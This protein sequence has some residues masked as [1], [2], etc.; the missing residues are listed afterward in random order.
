MKKFTLTL[1]AAG[2][3]VVGSA[4][5]ITTAS[6]TRTTAHAASARGPRGY[7]GYRGYRGNRGYR[8]PGGPAGP[9]GPQ[10]PV[11]PKGA[12]GGA[13]APGT[14]GAA[15]ATGREG[16]AGATGPAGPTGA[17]GP[18]GPGATS[19]TKLVGN[20]SSES[21]TINGIQLTETQ[22]FLGGACSAVQILN[23][24]SQPLDVFIDGKLAAPFIGLTNQNGVQTLAAPESTATFSAAFENGNAGV[25]GTVGDHYVTSGSG[26]CLTFGQF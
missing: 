21:V 9:A 20:G 17:T 19:F 13:G 3:L 2:L 14:A 24:T 10:G 22:P 6:A 11:G 1:A 5:G 15:G 7:R 4:Y 25:T 16:P 12:T 26:G 18:V 8:G 23:T